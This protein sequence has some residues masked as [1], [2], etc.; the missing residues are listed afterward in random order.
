M[1]RIEAEV[2]ATPAPPKA[3]V[4]PGRF[5]L[6]LAIVKKLLPGIAAA[7]A[8]GAVAFLVAQKTPA[9]SPLIWAVVIGAVFANL[10]VIPKPMAPGITF[11]AKQLL[12]LAVGFLGLRLAVSQVLAVGPSGLIVIAAAV[13]GTFVFT[14]FVARRFK[15]SR[16]LSAVLAAGTSICG[17]AAIVAVAGAVDAKDED[18]AVG[19]GAVTLYGTL[20]ML[21]YPLIGAALGLSADQFGLWAGASIHEVAQVVGAAFSFDAATATS[22]AELAT[23]VKLGRVLTLAPM[24]IVLTL[25]FRKGQDHRIR[26]QKAPLVPWF[27]TLFVITMAIRSLNLLPT[28]TVNALVQADT[29]LLAVAMGGLGLDLKWSK[30]RAAGLR[31][32]YVTGIATV[33]IAATSFGLVYLL[34]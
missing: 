34:R 9:L 23:V 25:M 10:N 8:V 21:I 14:S 18:T 30:V 3:P 19:V 22:S 16:P 24:A 7:F 13:V 2:S 4:A 31:P 20:A 27:I 28:G 32:L 26:G 5:A 33:F 1:S 6:K 15:L 29:F 17:A 11:S 12:R